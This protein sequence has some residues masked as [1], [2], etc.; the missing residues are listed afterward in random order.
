MRHTRADRVADQIK[1]EV[2]A[3]LAL[4]ARDPR[5]GFVTVTDVKVTPDLHHAKIF[6]SVHEKQDERLTFSALKKAVGFVRAELAK[7]LP[8]RRVP[9]LAFVPESENTSQILT[10]LDEVG[11]EEH[12]LYL[13]KEDH[14]SKE[15]LS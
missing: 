15:G 4:K 14:D 8:L 3:I 11:Y 1:K 9:D 7:Q 6:V 13:Q 12:R 2:A 5:I 10:L